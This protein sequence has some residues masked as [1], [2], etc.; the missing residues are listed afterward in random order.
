MTRHRVFMVIRFLHRR[1][2]QLIN[3]IFGAGFRQCYILFCFDVKR[4]LFPEY[5]PANTVFPSRVKKNNLNV[6]EIPEWVLAE[7]KVLGTHVDPA[8]YPNELFLATC[9]FYSYPVLPK[10]GKVYAQLIQQCTDDYYTHCFAIPWLKRGGADL[11]SLKH[12]EF[13]SKQPNSKVLVLLTEPGESPWLTRIQKDVDVLLVSQYESELTY[14]EMVIVISR[15][16]IQLRVDTLH[17]IN[18]RHVWEAINRYGLAIRQKT[19]I[20]ASLYCDDYDRN[21]LPVG[22]ARQYLVHCYPHLT[23]V[24]SDNSA[25]PAL[26]MQT[27]GFNSKL[28]SIIKSP[29]SVGTLPKRNKTW[30]NKV[31]WAGR[32]DRQ[33]RP[34]LL[35]RVARS[36][37]DMEFHVYGDS[38]L[39]TKTGIIEDLN[40][41]KNVHMHGGFDGVETLPFSDFPVFL[42]TSQWDG[43]PTM[44]IA[45]ALSAIPIVA[46][47]VGG[48]GD[49]INNETGYPVYNID[50]VSDYVKEI[51]SVFENSGE[52]Q[53][54]A[55]SARELIEKEYTQ[56]KFDSILLNTSGYGKV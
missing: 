47:C 2:D 26:L 56:Q 49:I 15:L 17:I 14:D 33:K 29:V 4:K 36:M 6:P 30:S 24:F 42:Y 9:Q 55:N 18:S 21:G 50:E 1:I 51:R 13:A 7:M 53:S 25:F 19:R 37:P 32:L 23:K 28:F 12:I 52:A 54:R 38:V 11:V 39:N 43:T 16:L 22:Y 3:S 46:S 31:L 10:P 40:K 45:A 34:D 27:Y 5:I 48:V 8:L 20:F 35:L 44:V 41:L